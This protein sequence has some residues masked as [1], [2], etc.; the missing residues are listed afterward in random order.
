M[1]AIPPVAESSSLCSAGSALLAID[2]LA[3]QQPLL[4]L[5]DSQVGLSRK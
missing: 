3:I 2:L 4:Q 1:P 5:R